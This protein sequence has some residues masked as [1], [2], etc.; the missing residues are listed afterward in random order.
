V[1]SD[2]TDLRNDASTPREGTPPEP[3]AP[4]R[5]QPTGARLGR[6]RARSKL[7]Q[8]LPLLHDEELDLDV[9][10]VLRRVLDLL[11]AAEDGGSDLAAQAAAAF[12]S[13]SLDLSRIVEEA[14]VGHADHLEQLTASL[15]ALQQPCQVALEHGVRPLLQRAAGEVQADLDEATWGMPYCPVCGSIAEPCDP[16]V[17]TCPRCATSWEGPYNPVSDGFRLELALP[18]ERDEKDWLD[19]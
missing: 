19:A 8:A 13:G 12:E 15:G 10:F 17:L 14:F 4:E 5:P 6:R 18:G 9:P 11:S 7:V 3:A 2:V 16:G 1:T